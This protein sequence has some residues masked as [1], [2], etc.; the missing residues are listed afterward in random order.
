MT[1]N[2]YQKFEPLL[3]QQRQQRYKHLL[4]VAIVVVIVMISFFLVGLFDW[5]R[6]AEGV[7]SGINLIGQMLPPDFSSAINWIKPLFD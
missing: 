5:E 2:S 3:K 1:T 6:L 7:P 4:Q